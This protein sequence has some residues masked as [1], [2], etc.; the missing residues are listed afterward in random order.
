MVMT[1]LSRGIDRIDFVEK[2]VVSIGNYKILQNKDP[3]K[4]KQN[5]H[6][7]LQTY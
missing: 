4:K 2:I 3:L 5:G 6:Q 7:T 1:H